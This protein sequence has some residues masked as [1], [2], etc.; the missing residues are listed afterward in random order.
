[1]MPRL[2]KNMQGWMIALENYLSMVSQ[3][4]YKKNFNIRELLIVP[5][6]NREIIISNPIG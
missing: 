4:Y 5:G 3:L 1:M 6:E 2:G